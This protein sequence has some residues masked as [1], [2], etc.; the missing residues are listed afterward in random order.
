MKKQ[1]LYEH[2]ATLFGGRQ[3]V[4][5]VPS[6]PLISSKAMKFERIDLLPTGA[7][8]CYMPCPLGCDC[9]C[10][11]ECELE[12]LMARPDLPPESVA[13]GVS[14]LQRVFEKLRDLN[15]VQDYPW[16]PS[17]SGGFVSEDPELSIGV[18][19]EV[20][21]PSPCSTHPG[22]RGIRRSPPWSWT[23]ACRIRWP[24]P[25]WPPRSTSNRGGRMRLTPPCWSPR[26]G[27]MTARTS[28]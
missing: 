3:L 16:K 19:L 14:T 10:A 13:Q 7:G 22:S 17:P 8:T 25:W 21:A 4:L 27:R 2:L 15:Q 23:A 18:L 6:F 1:C 12:G 26:R 5:P 24:Y 20:C 9:A 11:C 28:S